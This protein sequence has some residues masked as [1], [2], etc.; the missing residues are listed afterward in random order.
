M[1]EV[2]FDRGLRKKRRALSAT[3][4]QLDQKYET[5]EKEGLTGDDLQGAVFD[6]WAEVQVAEEEYQSAHDEKLVKEARRLEVPTPAKTEDSP[7]W[8]RGQ[9]YRL[10]YLTDKAHSDL[11]TAVRAEKRERNDGWIRWAVL[12]TG[13]LAASTGV[14]AVIVATLK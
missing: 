13:F 5:A 8:E 7:D 12:A 10:W 2:M 6:F 3:L 1:G 4:R 9:A 14:A 11:R